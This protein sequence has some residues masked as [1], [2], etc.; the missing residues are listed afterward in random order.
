MNFKLLPFKAQAGVSRPLVLVIAAV[1]ALAAAGALWMNKSDP[2]KATGTK[3]AV[4][5]PKAAASAPKGKPALT[6]NT[7]SVQQVSLPVS[8]AANGN[9]AAW[10]EASIGAES[11]GLRLAQ[12]VVNVGDRV[13]KGQLLAQFAADSVR[14]DLAQ[15]KAALAEAQAQWADAQ[16]NAE[17]AQSLKGTGALSTQQIDQMQT[18]ANAGK[19][20][21]Q[22]TQAAVDAQTIRLANATVLAPDSGVISARNASVGSVVGAGM[23]LFRLIR[24]ERLEWRA[25]VTSAEIPRVK[26][27]AT[28][29]VITA[30][31]GKLVGKV[32]AIAPTVDSTSRAALVYVDLPAGTQVAKAGM[33]A[34]GEFDLGATTASTV[35]QSA[36]VVRDGFSYLYRINDDQRVS[37]VKVQTGRIVG[38]NVELLTSVDPKAK[39]VATGAG[40]LNDGDLVRVVA[41]SGASGATAP[42]PA[43]SA[44]K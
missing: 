12:V 7:V 28:V 16:A 8:L 42:V 30:G 29:A 23:E 15:S 9:V 44:S 36:V 41:N 24:Q 22:A 19:A 6:V 31:G 40:F 14:A 25:E 33:F 27:G 43:A 38:D 4:E 20:R 13:Q 3:A 21:V 37:Q 1:V 10:Q 35:P 5:A 2:S 34:R 11:N 17:R 26:V 18:A 32:R 39:W